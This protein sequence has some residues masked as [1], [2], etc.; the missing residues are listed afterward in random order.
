[1]KGP[2]KHFGAI[3]NHTLKEDQLELE[4]PPDLN[5]NPIFRSGNHTGRHKSNFRPNSIVDLTQSRPQTV[6]E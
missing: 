4:A 1:M 5:Q 3:L 6:S 2:P